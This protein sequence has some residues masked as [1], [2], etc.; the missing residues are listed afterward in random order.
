MMIEASW[1]STGRCNQ[2]GRWICNRSTLRFVGYFGQGSQSRVNAGAFLLQL[3]NN[4]CEFVHAS[5]CSREADADA[6]AAV[7]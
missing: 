5:D 2:C 4:A 7:K 1:I 3:M 6:C